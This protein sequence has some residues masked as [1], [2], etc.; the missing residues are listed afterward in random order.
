VGKSVVIRIIDRRTG[1]WGHINVDHIFQSEERYQEAT[2]TVVRALEKTYLNFPVATADTVRRLAVEIEGEAP[3]EFDIHLAMGE[4]D[5]WVFM[6]V[7]AFRWKTAGISAELLEKDAGVL[8]RICNED[9]I[10]GAE[11]LYRETYRPQFHFTSRRGW[12]NDPNGLV[13]YDGEY[14]LF[15]Q[16][17]P[18]GRNWGN[19]HWGHAMSEDLVHWQEL[20]VALFPDELGT[21][22]SGSAVVDWNNTA[23]LQTGDEKTLVCIYT[24]AGASATQ[25]LAYSNDRGR[26]W[27]KFEGNPVLDH[28]I[29]GNRDPKVIWYEPERKWVMALFMDKNDF[30]LFSSPDLKQWERLCDVTIPGSSECPEFFEIALDGNEEDTRWVFYGGNALYLVGRFDWKTFTPE[31]GPR[32]LNYGNCFYASQTFTDIPAEDGRRI[33]IGWGTMQMPGMPFNQM[34]DFPVQLTLRRTTDGPRLF[35]QPVDEIEAI[36]GRRHAWAGLQLP[37]EG[38][39]LAGISGD[40]FEIHAEIELR[41]AAQVGFNVRGIPVTYDTGRKQLSCLGSS[42]PLELQDGTVRL[43]IL[44][45]RTSIEIFANDGQVYMPMGII[46]SDNCRSLDAFSRGGSARFVSLE[47]YEMNS[48]W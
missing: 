35:A 34:M 2:R 37:E 19:M 45:D 33:M 7:D 28:I 1:G 18:Y 22:F 23:G 8:E 48:A 29:G 17:N 44:V 31:S 36:R 14:H 24:A 47:I 25:C 43:R 4:P 6:D 13:H 42:A 9:A 40:L 21:C 20:P 30:A 11:N 27:E 10:K 32:R 46:P 3:R 16:H 41:D 26:T 12:N 15:Y 39:P 38:N 5:F